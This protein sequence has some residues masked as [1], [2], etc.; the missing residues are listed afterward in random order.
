MIINTG[1]RTDTVQYYTEWLLNRF[2]EG[3]VLSRNLL[4]PNKVKRY[5]LSPDVVDCVVFCSKNYKPILPNLRDITDRFNTYFHYTITAY[6]R[7]IEPRVPSIDESMQIL[8]EL[9]ETVRKR[10]V[11]WRYDSA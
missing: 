4:F 7:D 1:G 3:Y 8:I 5:E 9:S 6:G 2:N 11:T 10:R